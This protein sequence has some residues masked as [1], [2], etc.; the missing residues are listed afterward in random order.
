M[1]GAQA[2]CARIASTD[3]HHALAGGQNLLGMARR[4]GDDIPVAG[5]P[6]VL[7]RQEIHCEMD[8]VQLAAGHVEVPGLLGAPGKQ[9]GVK[10]LAQIL[11]RDVVAH[12]GPGLATDAFFHELPDAAI[13]V[14]LLELKIRDAVAQQAPRT[15]GLFENRDPVAGAVQL[16]RGGQAG[17]P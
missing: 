11:D 12:V 14:T 13:E 6:L 3:D 4:I 8:A 15:I 16:L 10:L 2:V 5:Q 9:Q 7:L 17:R 1:T